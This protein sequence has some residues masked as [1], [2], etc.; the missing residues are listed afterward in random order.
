MTEQASKPNIELLVMAL[1]QYWREGK[2]FN[3][4]CDKCG[5]LLEVTPKGEMASAFSIK[6]PCGWYND[7]MRGL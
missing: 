4:K 7:T 5:G 2:V 6:C 3:V 1:E